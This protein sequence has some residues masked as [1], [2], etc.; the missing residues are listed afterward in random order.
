MW[1]ID[2]DIEHEI[3]KNW[4]NKKMWGFVTLKHW[5]RHCHEI[6]KND[7]IKKSG[8]LWRWNIDINI[9]NDI[10][11]SFQWIS[12]SIMIVYKLI[13]NC[14]PNMSFRKSTQM[15]FIKKLIII[16]KNNF[17]KPTWLFFLKKL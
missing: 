4:K 10:E 13:V 17:R 12:N 9:D 14:V 5:H 16:R 2:Y 11:P 15:F 1:D 3:E 6:K 8:D 7:K